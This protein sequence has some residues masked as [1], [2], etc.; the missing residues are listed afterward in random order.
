MNTL[1]LLKPSWCMAARSAAVRSGSTVSG[2]NSV[3]VRTP[4]TILDAQVAGPAGEERL[5]AALVEQLAPAVAH[6]YADRVL[7]RV[8][9][10]RRQV[11]RMRA[12]PSCRATPPPTSRRPPTATGR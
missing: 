10:A 4:S 3:D 7:A 9:A 5:A 11:V 8:R 6:A 1:T 2:G 12:R